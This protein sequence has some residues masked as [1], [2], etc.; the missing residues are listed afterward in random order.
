MANPENFALLTD[1]YQ[2][3]M[4]QAYFRAQ[5]MGEATF[6]LFIRSY[7]PNRG[8]F[9]SAGLKDVLDYLQNFSFDANALDYLAERKL[10]SDDFL[11][12]LADLKFTGDVWAIPEGRIFFKDEPVLEVTA[13]II[14]AQLVETF[15]INQIHLQ[16]VIATKAARC[17]H[18][19]AGRPL[20]DFALRRTHGA[21]AGMKV[22]RA[23]YLAGFAGTSNVSAGQQYGIPIVGTMAHSFVMSFEH[24]IDAFRAYVSS[25]PN[26]SILLIDTYDTLSGARNAVQVAKE[27]AGRGEKLIGVRL[28]SGDL[29]EHAR[30]VRRIFDEAKLQEIKIIGSGGLDEYDLAEFS[31]ANLPFDSYGVGTKMGTSADAPWADM[32]YK[33]VDYDHRPVLKLS[34]GKNSW[35]GKKKIYRQLDD[36]G[37]L[38]KDII[39]TRQEEVPVAEPLLQKVME[40]GK[41]TTPLPSLNESRS[42][43]LQEFARFP[44]PFKEIRDP[45][46]YT[47]DF[48]PN[49]Q[50]L[51]A[52]VERKV[53]S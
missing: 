35:P 12:Y 8:Y 28:D 32:S 24:E 33:L 16:T 53:T 23:S 27:M 38:K 52:E 42:M 3:T 40:H 4:A 48:S 29:A 44:G 25:F 43:F 6:S 37:K 11:H 2:L 46:R 21:D 31:A 50:R 30:A 13:P 51:R 5:R 22:A 34:T 49:L 10:F 9:V 7:P 39:V 19:A 18:A 15:V 26:H 14:E 36:G 1:L 20:V 47:V 41:I 17:V 45:I